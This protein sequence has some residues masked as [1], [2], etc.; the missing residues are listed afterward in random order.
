M[1]KPKSKK[2]AARKRPTRKAKRPATKRPAAAS[3]ETFDA[4]AVLKSIASDAALKPTARVNAIR[5]LQPKRKEAG[6]TGD[7]VGQRALRILQREGSSV[8]FQEIYR[9][10][11]LHRWQDA[12]RLAVVRA[13]VDEVHNMTSVTELV[14]YLEAS[15]N[16][17]EARTFALAKVKAIHAVAAEGRATRPD[18]DLD[19]LA[20]CCAGLDAVE[21]LCPAKYTSLIDYGWGDAVDREVPIA[22]GELKA[23][24]DVADG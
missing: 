8:P 20:A 15:K 18:V 1:T 22:D 19:R 2:M 24:F 9:G 13:A 7:I 16:P 3:A 23:L 4:D 14:G 17:P 10:I 11:K 6:D 12:N 5:L 21:W